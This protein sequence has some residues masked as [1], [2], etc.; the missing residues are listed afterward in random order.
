MDVAD[1]AAVLARDRADPF[2]G[3]YGLAHILTSV[4]VDDC[5][6]RAVADAANSDVAVSP[7]T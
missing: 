7:L 2:D 1:C 4:E 3:M 5:A 6:R